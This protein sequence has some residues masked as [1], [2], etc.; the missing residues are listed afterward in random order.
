MMRTSLRVHRL[1]AVTPKL[2][3]DHLWS[4]GYFAAS[5]GGTPIAI[6]RQYI[7]NQRRALTR[8]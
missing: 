7:E 3:G 6:V 8:P 4:P 1:G 5:C 2:W